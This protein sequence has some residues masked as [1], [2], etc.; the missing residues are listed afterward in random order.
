MKEI[1][2]PSSAGKPFTWIDISQ[3]DEQELLQVAEEFKLHPY[4]VRD[5]MERGHL[6]KIETV[7][8]TTFII[9]RLYN[10]KDGKTDSVQ[11]ITSKVA[12]FYA[13]SFVI[14]IH[15]VGWPFTE[16]VKKRF[17][18]KKDV[19]P[20]KIVTHLLWQVIHTYEKPS[21]EL[22]QEVDSYESRIFL[23][24]HIKDLQQ[25]LYYLKRKAEMGK[26]MLV[27]TTDV[28]N[29]VRTKEKNNPFLQDVLDLHV[30]MLTSYDQVISSLNNLLSIYISLS[31]QRTNETMKVMTIF[32]AF[33]LPLTF[34][35]GLYGMNFKYMPEINEKWGYPMTWVVMVIISFIIYLWF[36]RKK[37]L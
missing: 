7:D 6:P 34:I 20:L 31:A 10:P 19:T 11:D 36:K 16:E 23:K 1:I 15:R 13:D 3:P 28:I 5:S 17:Q 18:S 9:T 35:V 26:R 30:K 29:V 12:I 27:L 33:F 22:L 32:S 2:I 8:N 21:A 37:W 4:T 25:S 14:T 24:E